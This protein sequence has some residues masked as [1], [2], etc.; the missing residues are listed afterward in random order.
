MAKKTRPDL[1]SER[2]RA[3]ELAAFAEA[4][5]SRLLPVTVGVY[6][7]DEDDVPELVGS[8]VLVMLGETR[9]LFSARHVLDFRQ[10]GHLMIGVSPDMVW[11][12][13]DVTRLRAV[14]S[15]SAADDHIDIGIVRLDNDSWSAVPSTAFVSW[16]EPR[17]R[18]TNRG[19][20]Y[21]RA[22]W[23]PSFEEPSSR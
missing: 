14:G 10:K 11:L 12:S 1:E 19:Q 6:L 20:S 9:F 2:K 4:L 21:L 18:R 15:K 17:C 16:Q 5:S 22:R 8:G 13:G 23:V 7:P 3:A